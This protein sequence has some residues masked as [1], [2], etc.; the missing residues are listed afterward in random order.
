MNIHMLAAIA[1]LA[2]ILLG[3]MA[4]IWVLVLLVNFIDYLGRKM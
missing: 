4:F 2:F 1:I 3:C